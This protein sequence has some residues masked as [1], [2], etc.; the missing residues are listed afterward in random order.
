M[1]FSNTPASVF[2]KQG[3]SIRSE[4]EVSFMPDNPNLEAEEDALL[5]EVLFKLLKNSQSI[6]FDPEDNQ[7]R[8]EITDISRELRELA[9]FDG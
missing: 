5:S 7:A 8:R 3:L 4:D 9:T 1:M 2:K 6:K